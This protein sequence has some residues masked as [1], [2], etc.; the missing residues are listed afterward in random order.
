MFNNYEFLSAVRIVSGL[1][2]LNILPEIIHKLSGSKVFIM[3]DQGIVAAKA[4]L[5]VIEVLTAHQTAYTLF[6][7]VPADG[8]I[9]SVFQAKQLF[10]DSQSDIIIAVGGGSVI[11]TAKALN[12]AVSLPEDLE[13][14]MGVNNLPHRLKPCI[15]I[16]TT[17]GTGSE[18]TAVA[19]VA[20][21]QKKMKLIFNSPYLMADYAIL[22]PK[23]TLNL[24]PSITAMTAM[25][26]LTHCIEAYT[27]N[28]KNPI[29]SQLAFL[30]IKKILTHLPIVID[31]PKN[32]HSRLE[33]AE[34]S[35]MAGMAFSNSMVGLTHSLAHAVGANFGVPHGLC[36]SIF[37]PH[38]LKFNQDHILEELNELSI[39]F[40]D[41]Q[42]YLSNTPQQRATLMIQKISNLK[43]IL[44]QK[45]KLPAKLSL[46]DKVKPEDFNLIMKKALIDGSIIYN[47]IKPSQQQVLH[48]LEQAW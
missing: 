24:P 20:D 29:S 42:E 25:D 11:D 17:A 33:L 26:A 5:P 4:H 7:Q 37:L 28:G 40:L 22:D 13:K 35:T 36:C 41:S 46:T 32:Q 47:P 16:P 12:I 19:I 34:A 43:Q 30:A 39:L 6:D 48:I 14:Y 2:T 3:T 1:E 8:S 45:S 9:A 15:I 10:L 21:N 44:Q 27:C 38:V 31:D 18:V 23:M